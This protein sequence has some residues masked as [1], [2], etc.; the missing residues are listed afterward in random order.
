M[1]R[2]KNW[3][4]NFSRPHFFA[5][6]QLKAQE[7][8]TPHHHYHDH[9]HH[10]EHSVP[11][12]RGLKVWKSSVLCQR[13]RQVSELCYFPHHHQL[14]LLLL[15]QLLLLGVAQLL[16]ADLLMLTSSVKDMQNHK[17]DKRWKKCK[18]WWKNRDKLVTSKAGICREL[19]FKTIFIYL[20]Q[21]TQYTLHHTVTSQL[22]NK[23]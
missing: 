16:S 14:L 15:L 2:N 13:R 11:W 10:E 18:K 21:W 23:A 19:F 5:G 1:S 4:K 12:R 8:F 22:D 6:M 7:C 20:F 3:K 17:C 9:H